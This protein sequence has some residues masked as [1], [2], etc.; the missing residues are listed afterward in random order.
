MRQNATRP[1]P[2]GRPG[3]GNNDRREAPRLTEESCFKDSPNGG[4]TLFKNTQGGGEKK[5][6][7]D[8]GRGEGESFHGHAQEAYVHGRKRQGP[9]E[10]PVGAES[11]IA[12]FAREEPG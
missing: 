6:R 4:V 8:R 2:A 5:A 10:K 11:F 9:E 3:F 7:L 1:S 12:R